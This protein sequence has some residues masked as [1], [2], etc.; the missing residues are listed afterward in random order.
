MIAIT[1]NSST[2][3]KPRLST[4]A[5]PT[6]DP[7]SGLRQHGASEDP[8]HLLACQEL[9]RELMALAKPELRAADAPLDRGVLEGA[10]V[11]MIVVLQ[12]RDG[13]ANGMGRQTCQTLNLSDVFLGL[14]EA[15]RRE[16][17]PLRATALA[18]G[19][20]Q[21]RSFTP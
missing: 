2:R 14:A 13:N 18:G 4:E 7:R 19:Y 12:S 17:Q 5:F 9:R 15:V 3:V 21:Y 8:P 1:T 20:T 10:Y 11:I 6:R 16:R